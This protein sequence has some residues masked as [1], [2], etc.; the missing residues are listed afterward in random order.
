MTNELA[1][2]PPRAESR[3]ALSAVP[4]STEPAAPGLFN[5]MTTA[6]LA[7][8][9]STDLGLWTLDFGLIFKSPGD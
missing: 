9:C 4:S 8:R 2:G 5:G 1:R 3:P 6:D 7:V